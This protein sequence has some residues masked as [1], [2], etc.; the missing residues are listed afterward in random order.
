MYER[1]AKYKARCEL[2]RAHKPPFA[3]G[4]ADVS[5][6]VVA[7]FCVHTHENRFLFDA[8]KAPREATELYNKNPSGD[9]VAFATQLQF[10]MGLVTRV[11]DIKSNEARISADAQRAVEK[12]LQNVNSKNAFDWANV[13]EYD[14]VIEP[15]KDTTGTHA[16]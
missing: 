5:P 10:A 12:E 2:V 4:I 9:V 6:C 8:K 13:M 15:V 3:K 16:Q 1:E 14:D 11:V 7:G